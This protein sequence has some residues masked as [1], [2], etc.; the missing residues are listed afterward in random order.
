MIHFVYSWSPAAVML[1]Y[2]FILFFLKGWS[3]FSISDNV[4]LNNI[5]QYEFP[6]LRNLTPVSLSW[7]AGEAQ[8]ITK[9]YIT[10]TKYNKNI[11]SLITSFG[12]VSQSAA[13]VLQVHKW[14]ICVFTWTDK[15]D[16]SK[17]TTVKD[18]TGHTLHAAKYHKRPHF[19]MSHVRLNVSSIRGT[20]FICLLVTQR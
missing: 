17:W 13:G 7:F 4:F 1:K 8:Q 16:M 15:S 5:V 14:R 6:F 11:S 2:I 12:G 20:Y 10:K 3:T 9:Y 18:A 19:V